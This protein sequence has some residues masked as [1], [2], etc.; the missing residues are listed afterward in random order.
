MTER[1]PIIKPA[2][3]D[4]HDRRGELFIPKDTG[5]NVHWTQFKKGENYFNAYVRVDLGERYYV[6]LFT[7]LNVGDL[8]AECRIMQLP[9]LTPTGYHRLRS[10]LE[11]HYPSLPR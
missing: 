7:F 1:K 6:P 5:R 11:R 4:T 8:V 9:I 10:R 3:A 2:S